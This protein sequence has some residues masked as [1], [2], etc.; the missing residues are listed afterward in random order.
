[1]YISGSGPVR[2]SSELPGC[3]V[4]MPSKD[5]N[6]AWF[7]IE[8]IKVPLARPEQARVV[9]SPRIFNDLVAP[10]THGE[11]PEDSAAHARQIDQAKAAGLFIA[12]VPGDGEIIIPP[13]HSRMMLDSIVKARGGS[14]AP[15]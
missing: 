14:G 12:D 5:P 3:V 13:E 10:K 9:S 1:M 2:S 8:V 4:G 6:S 11:A 15:T 7:R